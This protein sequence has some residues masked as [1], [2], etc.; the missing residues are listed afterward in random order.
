MASLTGE[1]LV[2]GWRA[3]VSWRQVVSGL[4]QIAWGMA[5]FVLAALIG[6]TKTGAWGKWLARREGEGSRSVG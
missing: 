1:A 3:Y 5:F 6:V 4:D 2:A